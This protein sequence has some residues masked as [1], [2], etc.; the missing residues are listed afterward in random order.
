[1]AFWRR[2]DGYNVSLDN[3]K[4]CWQDFATDEGGGVLDLV[5]R[6]RDC[7]RAEAYRWLAAEFGLPS[8]NL[9]LAQRRE[10]ARQR[11]C[12][13]QDVVAARLFADV[14]VILAEQALEKMHPCDLGRASLTGLLAALRSET[15][16][17]VK[18]REWRQK[19]PKLTRG[20]VHAGC[21]RKERLS[22]L[23]T[24]YLTT[25]EASRAA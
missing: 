6:I 16:T 2:G 23:I 9:T 1:M 18:Y 5:Q 8:S 10:F 11:A 21:K 3:T 14:A 20:L 7:P 19:K 17:L 25:M 12:D 13:E 15:G 22:M 4:G 24:N